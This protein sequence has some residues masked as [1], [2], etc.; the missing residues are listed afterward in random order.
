MLADV[1]KSPAFVKSFRPFYDE[2]LKMYLR[3]YYL[4]YGIGTNSPGIRSGYEAIMAKS[5]P[6]ESEASYFLQE[7]FSEFADTL[8]GGWSDS[9]VDGGASYDWFEAVTCPG[10]WLRRSMDGTADEFYGLLKLTLKT[11]DPAFLQKNERR[12]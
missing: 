11:F 6:Q 9:H 10:F 12:K 2:Q 1:L 4:S 7:S 3:T 8:S 5:V